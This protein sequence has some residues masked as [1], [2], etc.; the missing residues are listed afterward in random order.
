MTLGP[1][2]VKADDAPTYAEVEEP[3]GETRGTV[4]LAP[5][6]GARRE[7]PSLVFLAGTFRGLGYR[8]VRF[9]F[10]YK[11]AGRSFPDPMPVCMACYR[12]VMEAVRLAYGAEGE[13]VLAGQSM[14]G[15]VASMLA[16]EGEPC[17]RLVCFAY[18]LHPQG[19]PD[20]LRDAHL[21]AITVPTLIVNGS[22][23][24]LCTREL[25]EGVLARLG[26]N[27]SMRWLEGA[28]HSLKPAKGSGRRRKELEAEV[29]GLLADWAG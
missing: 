1:I 16:A 8:T 7:S 13:Q 23:D 22:A 9:D 15:R 29:V 3:E 5:S 6:A 11:A 28:D 20:K 2:I 21:P 4:F 27:V 19:K 26:S 14:G 12:R 24:A 18:P 10:L 25:M 17:D